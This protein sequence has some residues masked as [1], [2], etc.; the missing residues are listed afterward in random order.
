M[1]LRQ[2]EYLQAVVEEKTFYEAAE[3]CHVS[4]SA[5]SEASPITVGK[6]A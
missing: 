1:L 6:P 3:R 2:I 4:Q 5:I